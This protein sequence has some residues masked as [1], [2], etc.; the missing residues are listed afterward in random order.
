MI[1]KK[2]I[3]LQEKSRVTGLLGVKARTGALVSELERCTASRVPTKDE[4]DELR[5]RFKS[6]IDLCEWLHED[7]RLFD[8][9]MKM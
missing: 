7:E 1:K 2:I 5:V 8:E 9:L 6:V 3:E 4:I